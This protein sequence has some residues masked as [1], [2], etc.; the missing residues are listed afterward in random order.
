MIVTIPS[1]PEYLKNELL[2]PK[3]KPLWKIS[4]IKD[5]MLIYNMNGVLIGQLLDKGNEVV[6]AVADTG[7][8]TV[9]RNGKEI[10]I[11][12][13][14]SG[15]STDRVIAGEFIFFG[16]AETG[17]YEVFRKYPALKKPKSFMEAVA[18]PINEKL[19]NIRPA[20]GENTLLATLM[21]LAIGATLN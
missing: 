13:V 19:I 16:K 5:G 7:S 21:G 4:G 20:D 18:H 9:S 14:L 15:D 17:H 10:T 1:R 2:I 11:K 12:S 3:D 6:V 8:L